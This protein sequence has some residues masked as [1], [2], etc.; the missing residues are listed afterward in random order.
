VFLIDI[1][2]FCV[3]ACINHR[4][5]LPSANWLQPKLFGDCLRSRAA[6]QKHFVQAREGALTEEG[7]I[8]YDWSE[9]HLHPGRIHVYE[10]WASSATLEAHLQ[11]HWYRDM[12]A[13]MGQFPM[14]PPTSVIKKYRVEH[15]EPVYVDGVATGIFSDGK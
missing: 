8:A 5:R 1:Q 2:C 4:K 6:L 7:C 11:D 13:H 12:G 9:D 3:S 14:K 10:E 15:E